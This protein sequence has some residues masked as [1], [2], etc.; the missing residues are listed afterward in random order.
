MLAVRAI[1]EGPPVVALH[2]FTHTSA[3]FDRL[4]ATCGHTLVAIDLPGHGSSRDAATDHAT[5][6]ESL[7]R[8]IT[9]H[10]EV[11]VPVLGYSQGARV[12]LAMAL[13]HPGVVSSLVLVSGTAGIADATERRE[14]AEADHALAERI[15]SEGLDTFLETWTSTGITSTLHRSPDE[16]SEDL[17]RRSANTPDGLVRA[18]LG[19]GQGTMPSSWHRLGELAIPTLLITGEL[20][21]RY[22]HIA[23][24]MA[25]ALPN[26]RV[27]VVAG[28]RHDPIGDDPAAVAAVLSAFLDGLC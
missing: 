27:E 1:G 13:D 21:T 20:D 5:V 28:A 14:R 22:T 19:Y 9:D 23:H 4:G 10:C 11:P 2:G 25:A 8:T 6:V 7:A 12:A 18:L 17:G 16:R 24:T 15:R 26:A 3:Q